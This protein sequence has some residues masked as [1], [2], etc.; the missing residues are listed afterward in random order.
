MKTM[1]KKNLMKACAI[2]AVAAI[3][4]AF[5]SMNV[6]DVNAD[7]TTPTASEFYMTEGA[8]VRTTSDE[9]GIRFNAT[10]TKAYWEALQETYGADATY[11]FY[12]VV[13]D[14]TTPIT[15]D[16][17]TLTPDFTSANDYT[18]Y[19]TI[20]YT[21]DELETAGLL[22]E[23]CELELSAQ[24]YVDVTKAGET[25]PTTIAA[26][27]TTGKRSMKAVANAAALAGNEDED[28]AKY[29]T[30]GKRS[31]AIECYS[32]SDKSGAV[33]MAAMP[34]W[35]NDM[36]V[37]YGAE[38]LNAAL[39]A[40]GNVSFTGFELPEGQTEGY[41]SV[42]NGST[43]YSAKV[44]TAL[45]ITQDAVSSLMSVDADAVIYL[46]E[47]VT[48]EGITW[49]STV[50]FAGVFDGGNHVID[51]FTVP[52]NANGYQGFFRNFANG[53][54]VKNVAFTN[55]T[56]GAN[57]GVLAGQFAGAGLAKAENVFVYVTKT[58]N[59][60]TSSRYSLIER[61]NNDG[62]LD[63]TNVVLKM[64]GVSQNETVLGYNT[65]QRCT[66][67][68]V[69]WISVG[70]SNKIAVSTSTVPAQHDCGKY[71]NIEAF[72]SATKTLTPFLTSCVAKYFNNAQ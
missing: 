27:G 16:Y 28:L 8:A 59:S 37:Y 53:A 62:A 57:S 31:E 72:N 69:H 55:V 54:L 41:M 23:A 68:N 38:K 20:V 6:V 39:D 65:K 71:A 64:P 3:P 4:V 56:M 26:Y 18:F 17:G 21:T 60:T 67:T 35:T 66:L 47:D 61:T 13:T 25:E 50:D 5:A 7:T 24:T 10:I 29:F 45:K 36:E 48:L 2:L 42:F 19:S 11:S 14:G 46:A 44:S 40:K 52:S 33:N 70:P 32:F 9:V 15:K 1:M 49:S 34:A 51:K 12:S 22:E 58:G 63:L 30:V 43:V